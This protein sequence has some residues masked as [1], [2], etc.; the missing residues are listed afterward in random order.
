MIFLHHLAQVA[1]SLLALVQ[2]SAGILA[3]GLIL[4]VIWAVVGA[5]FPYQVRRRIWGWH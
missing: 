4:G 5:F 2:Y 1:D 3:V